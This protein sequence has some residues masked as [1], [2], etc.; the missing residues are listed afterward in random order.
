MEYKQVTDSTS[1]QGRNCI[2]CD[3]LGVIL[4]YF[5]HSKTVAKYD[6]R[7]RVSILFVQTMFQVTYN[8]Q[9]T[10]LGIQR[11]YKDKENMLSLRINR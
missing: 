3:K 11:R 2:G 5:Y 6:K 4:G 1:T 10:M 7:S 9:G 8:G